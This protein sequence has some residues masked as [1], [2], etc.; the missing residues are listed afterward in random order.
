MR[1]HN[2]PGRAA[3]RRRCASYI[4][5]SSKGLQAL[6]EETATYS[7]DYGSQRRELEILQH[8]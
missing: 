7:T 5:P 6:D 2:S 8:L 3:A 1:H 4:H